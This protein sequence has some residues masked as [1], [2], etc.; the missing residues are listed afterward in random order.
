MPLTGRRRPAR[1]KNL[2]TF[3][4]ADEDAEEN[5]DESLHIALRE[6]I[7][8][9]KSDGTTLN[10]ADDGGVPAVGFTI[11]TATTA[12]TAATGGNNAGDSHSEGSKFSLE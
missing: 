8:G 7:R 5:E 10:T 1:I 4:N 6:T 9:D 12:A 3:A 2:S 11:G